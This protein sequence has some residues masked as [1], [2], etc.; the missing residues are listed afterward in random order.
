M[1]NLLIGLLGALMATNPPAAVSNLV[2]QTTGLSV[3]VSDSNDPVEIEFKKL[4]TDDDAAM[5]EI[6]QW[7]RDNNAFVEKGGETGAGEWTWLHAC[8]CKARSAAKRPRDEIAR[9]SA[10]PLRSATRTNA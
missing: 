5:A 9:S 4:M 1:S 3:K 2:T 8:C 10:A 6:D 7:I